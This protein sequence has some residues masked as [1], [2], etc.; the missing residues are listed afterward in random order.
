MKTS[1]I[2]FLS[3]FAMMMLA[4]QSGSAQIPIADEPTA[5]AK[6]LEIDPYALQLGDLADEYTLVKGDVDWSNEGATVM[7]GGNGEYVEASG[8]L[9]GEFGRYARTGDKSLPLYIL[10]SVTEYAD[11]DATEAILE[12]FKA[13]QRTCFTI[14][15]VDLE[16]LDSLEGLD[17]QHVVYRDP[18]GSAGLI[19]VHG[20][21][22]VN[23]IAPPVA[24]NIDS[25][26]IEIAKKQIA[27]LDKFASQ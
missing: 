8:R 19:L 23:L 10:Y 12:I 20:S 27:W 7:C 13:G 9:Y 21:M 5:T 16:I 3:I 18:E 14:A 6:A 25:N 24:G 2:F 17:V 26:L 4:C 1:H 11:T 22:T 15:P